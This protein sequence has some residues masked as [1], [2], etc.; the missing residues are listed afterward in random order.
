MLPANPP[1]A[2]CRKHDVKLPDEY[3]QIMTDLSPFRGFSP[4]ELLRRVKHLQ[5]LRDTFAMTN[6]NGKLTLHSRKYDTTIKGA[7]DRAQGQFDFIKDVSKDIPDFEA[8]F[9]IHECVDPPSPLD[10]RRRASSRLTLG[11]LPTLAPARRRSSS[12]TRT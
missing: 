4:A 11:S 3:D 2:P 12:R 7:D 6:K 10:P 8:T 9:A 5:T 1:F